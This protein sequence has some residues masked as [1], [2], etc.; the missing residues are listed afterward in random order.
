MPSDTI[1]N[2]G[3][4]DTLLLGKAPQSFL[5]NKN[6]AGTYNHREATGLRA[7][8]ARGQKTVNANNNTELLD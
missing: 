2:K 1:R 5:W 4:T 3:D 6:E 8:G 7:Q